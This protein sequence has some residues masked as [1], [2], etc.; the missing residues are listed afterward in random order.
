MVIQDERESCL[1]SADTCQQ[2]LF[3]NLI[4]S[5]SPLLLYIEMTQPYD[6]AKLRMANTCEQ[7]KHSIYGKQNFLFMWCQETPY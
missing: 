6:R 5:Y 4:C 1:P 2:Q 3:P 7:I